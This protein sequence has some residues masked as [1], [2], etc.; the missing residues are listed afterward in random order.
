MP[1]LKVPDAPVLRNSTS[2]QGSTYAGSCD[3]CDPPDA[4]EKRGS[5]CHDWISRRRFQIFSLMSFRGPDA[6]DH[7]MLEGANP[8]QLSAP[9][10]LLV[11][12]LR[13]SLF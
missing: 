5:M 13:T 6:A 10:C 12:P 8:P 1:Y 2:R 7:L 3:R 11:V 4:D 9:G